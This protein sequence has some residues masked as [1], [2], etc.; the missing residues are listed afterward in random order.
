MIGGVNAETA[1]LFAL[2]SILVFYFPK[3]YI[4]Q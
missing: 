4:Q 2:V 3:I 1:A